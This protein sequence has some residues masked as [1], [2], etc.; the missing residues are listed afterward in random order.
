M[1]SVA[2]ASK[3]TAM[4]SLHSRVCFHGK[5]NPVRFVFHHKQIVIHPVLVQIT[6][7]LGV[8]SRSKQIN[9]IDF[10]DGHNRTFVNDH[11]VDVLAFRYETFSEVVLSIEPLRIPDLHQADAVQ[12]G[13]SGLNGR[14]LILDVNDP[15]KLV[16]ARSEEHTSELESRENLVCRL[17]LE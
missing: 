10:G 16:G 8:L 7:T 14:A 3:T 1:V 2:I 9:R 6:I 5:N 17:L 13:Y 11:P 4:L 15:L 12:A